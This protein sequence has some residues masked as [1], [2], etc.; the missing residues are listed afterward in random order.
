MHAFVGGLT[1]TDD[2]QGQERDTSAQLRVVVWVRDLE[3]G[4]QC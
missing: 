2:E 1:G 4:C 3:L